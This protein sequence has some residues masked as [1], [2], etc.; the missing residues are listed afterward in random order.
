MRAGSQRPGG[1]GFALLLVLALVAVSSLAVAVA[2]PAWSQQLRREREHE[3][4]RVGLLY[5]Q[6]LQSYRDA[7]PGSVRAYP[8]T[9]QE[10]VR[11]PRVSGVMR[12]LRRLHPDPLAPQRPWGVVR[13]EYGRIVGVYSLDERAPLAAGPVALADRTLPAARRYAD[14]KFMALKDPG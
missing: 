13:D 6:A 8:M 7:L 1:R 10:L 3:L 4:W 2:G 9:L 11:D 14:W 12:H 5:A